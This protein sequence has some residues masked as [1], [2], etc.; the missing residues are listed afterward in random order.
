MWNETKCGPYR[1]CWQQTRK[2]ALKVVQVACIC[3]VVAVALDHEEQLLHDEIVLCH[4]VSKKIVVVHLYSTVYERFF[5]TDPSQAREIWRHMTMRPECTQE[6]T[7]WPHTSS[8]HHTKHCQWNNTAY[9][10]SEKHM[11]MLS[12]AWDPYLWKCVNVL[13]F[14]LMGYDNL[15]GVEIGT[16]ETGVIA[17]CNRWYCKLCKT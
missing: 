8:H 5:V 10:I 15:R 4:L 7:R 3:G 17:N 6:H 9:F 12:N 1:G 2:V 14:N 11:I 13:A 16:I